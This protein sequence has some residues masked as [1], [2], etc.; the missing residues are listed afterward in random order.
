MQDEEYADDFNEMTFR[1]DIEADPLDWAIR[2][3]MAA[4]LNLDGRRRRTVARKDSNFYVVS[5]WFDEET[6]I[7]TI[8]TTG[9]GSAADIEV[10]AVEIMYNITEMEKLQLQLEAGS[11]TVSEL[12][13]RTVTSLLP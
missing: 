6:G 2:Y 11:L 3:K 1:D 8:K 13:T 5:S 9:V 7:Q 10:P 4:I 12:L